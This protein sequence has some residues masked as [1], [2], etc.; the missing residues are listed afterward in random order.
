MG[1]PTV[2]VRDATERPETVECGSNV[3]SGLDPDAIRSCV[4]LSLDSPA[5]WEAPAEY[6]VG[7]VSTTVANIVLGHGPLPARARP[8]TPAQTTEDA[9]VVP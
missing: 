9:T 6:L 1:V 3:L 5:S 7:D 4:E 2:T 8:E